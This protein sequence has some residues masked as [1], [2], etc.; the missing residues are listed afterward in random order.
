MRARKQFTRREVHSFKP[1]VR[2]ILKCGTE[3]ELMQFLRGI[4]IP[5]EDPR[6]AI[7]VTAWRAARA[8]KL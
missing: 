3:F 6:F 7:A 2:K 5:D 1:D 8:G 4:G